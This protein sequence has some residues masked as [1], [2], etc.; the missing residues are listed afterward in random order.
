MFVS[1]VSSGVGDSVMGLHNDKVP[2]SLLVKRYRQALGKS[3]NFVGLSFSDCQ[4]SLTGP[5]P[6]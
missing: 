1:D 3:F 2:T 5:L 6:K 4:S